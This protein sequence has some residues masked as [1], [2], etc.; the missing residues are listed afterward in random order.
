LARVYLAERTE[1][2]ASGQA[3]DR[4]ARTIGPA[5]DD[6]VY[7]IGDPH[8][9]ARIQVDTHPDGQ[10]PFLIENGGR[11][12]T[13]DTTEA[14]TLIRDWLEQSQSAAHPTQTKRY[15]WFRPRPG[16]RRSRRTA[17][18]ARAPGWPSWPAMSWMAGRRMRQRVGDRFTVITTR[19]G[20]VRCSPGGKAG[21]ESQSARS[22]PL[23]RS[24]H[25]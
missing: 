9:L 8:Q 5:D 21:C 1:P 2:A 13:T 6:N 10:P 3:S 22:L 15:C 18:F 7:F 16:P 24:R 25:V 14:V 17:R 11:H 19:P 12:H 4:S 20:D 23:R